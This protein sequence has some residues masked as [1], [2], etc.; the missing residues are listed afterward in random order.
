MFAWKEQKAWNMT[1]LADQPLAV[2]M[3]KLRQGEESAQGSRGHQWC[4]GDF[5]SHFLVPGGQLSA[6]SAESLGCIQTGRAEG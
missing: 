2:G 6:L 5:C 4:S 1:L 3:G